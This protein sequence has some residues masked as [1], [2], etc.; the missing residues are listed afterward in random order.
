MSVK[1]LTDF[2]KKS[3]KRECINITFHAFFKQKIYEIYN[4]LRFFML[5]MLLSKLLI[6]LGLAHGFWSD[7]QILARLTPHGITSHRHVT[8]VGTCS[9]E[10]LVYHSSMIMTFYASP[11]IP[12]FHHLKMEKCTSLL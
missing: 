7:Q 9:K 8:N 1:N 11:S 2:N 4:F 10:T 3:V 12:K 5:C 6:H